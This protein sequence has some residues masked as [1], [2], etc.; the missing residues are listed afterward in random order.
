MAQTL[1]GRERVLALDMS[2]FF[3][4]LSP[5]GVVDGTWPVVVCLDNVP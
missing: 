1:H 3:V 5:H 4:P 2:M